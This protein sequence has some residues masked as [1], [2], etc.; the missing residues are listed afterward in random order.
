MPELIERSHVY[1]GL[2]PLYK[3]KQGKP[4]A[5]PPRTMALNQYLI[6][7]A[8]EGAELRYSPE[9]LPSSARRWKSSG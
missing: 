9:A 3:L 1:I 8:V 2:P 4:G 7:N 6:A 5:L